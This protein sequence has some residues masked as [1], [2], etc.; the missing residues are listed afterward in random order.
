MRGR[1]NQYQVNVVGVRLG[2][3]EAPI[4]QNCLYESASLHGTK[5]VLEL[6]PQLHATITS[7]KYPKAGLRF[8]E[9]AIVY[10]LRQHA[11][12]AECRNRHS[13]L[14][15]GSSE[16]SLRNATSIASRESGKM[17]L[18]FESTAARNRRRVA[19]F[20]GISISMRP[21]FSRR[22]FSFPR[23]RSMTAQ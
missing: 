23:A 19:R 22:D 11:I 1:N 9:C 10:P 17:Q 14:A 2:G 5:K 6:R 16:N 4:Q 8:F 20:E 3:D 7:S 15:A 18:S 13:Y 21:F 12:R